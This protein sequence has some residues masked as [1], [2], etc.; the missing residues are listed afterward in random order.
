LP[1]AGLAAFVLA[2]TAA[3]RLLANDLL[4]PTPWAMLASLWDLAAHDGR[5]WGDI[6]A[7]LRR[8]FTGFSIAVAIAVP[9]GL[10]LAWSPAARGLVL[11]IVTFL[12]PIPPIAWIPLAI[13]WLGLGDKPGCFITALAAFFPVFL[14]SYDGARNVERV[15]VHAARSLGAKRWATVTRVYLPSS[16]PSIWT[17]LRIGLG[18]SWMAVVT[19]ELI[20]AHSGLGYMI[21]LS[22]LNLDTARVIVGMCVIGAIGAAM[23]VLLGKCERLLLPW[24]QE[25]GSP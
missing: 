19:A 12:R 13:L 7:S 25:R 2:W 23:T 15:H 24:R 10:F 22:R 20:A 21:Q 4:L 14:N 17:G 18:Q 5:L 1:A 11:P 6:G 9:L 8:V 3:A 16:L